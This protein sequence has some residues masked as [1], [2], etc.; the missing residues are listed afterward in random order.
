M[1]CVRYDT[2]LCA[3]R[4]M[5]KDTKHILVALVIYAKCIVSNFCQK[6][7]RFLEIKIKRTLKSSLQCCRARARTIFSSWPNIDFVVV[8]PQTNRHTCTASSHSYSASASSLVYLWHVEQQA[9]RHGI[10]HIR[11]NSEHRERTE[12]NAI[13]PLGIYQFL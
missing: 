7:K 9:K 1:T 8:A 11:V 12:W 5:E 4:K 6:E 2:F 13:R 3:S 10:L